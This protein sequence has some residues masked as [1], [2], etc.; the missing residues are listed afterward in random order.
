VDEYTLI[1]ATKLAIESYFVHRQFRCTVD[2]N[3]IRVHLIGASSWQ[4]SPRCTKQECHGQIRRGA[5]NRCAITTKLGEEQVN[6]IPGAVGLKLAVELGDGVGDL[7]GGWKFLVL[8]ASKTRRLSA[9][10]QG[11]CQGGVAKGGVG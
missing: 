1:L 6:N 7:A 3:D 8:G 4:L 10:G 9:S 5:P 11:G 2:A